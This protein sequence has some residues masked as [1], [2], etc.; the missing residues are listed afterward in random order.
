MNYDEKRWFT[1]SKWTLETLDQAT[2]NRGSTESAG[3]AG[4]KKDIV[5]EEEE[6]EETCRKEET[7]VTLEGFIKRLYTVVIGIRSPTPLRQMH[8]PC[9]LALD[10][11][12]KRFR[13]YTS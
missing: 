5:E 1:Q 6:E 12:L 2:E 4:R 10:A 13:Q 8:L 3:F 11:Y 7:D 9:I